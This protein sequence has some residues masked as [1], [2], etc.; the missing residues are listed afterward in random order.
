PTRVWAA[1]QRFSDQYQLT[2]PE[3]LAAG[4]YPLW[5]GMYTSDSI[6]RLPLTVAGEQQPNNVLQIGIIEVVAP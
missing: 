6:E 3:D 5:L 2:L 1:G 4:S